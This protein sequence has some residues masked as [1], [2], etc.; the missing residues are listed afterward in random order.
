M[1]RRLWRAYRSD[2]S[3]TRR[4]QSPIAPTELP[5]KR[6]NGERLLE[7]IA[8]VKRRF[9]LEAFA[10]RHKL[11]EG[12]QWSTKGEEAGRQEFANGSCRFGARTHRTRGVEMSS[13]R[14]HSGS[15]DVIAARSAR[16]M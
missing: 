4:V 2:P 8:I 5:A 9:S 15:I 1:S 10:P 12:K 13:I 7:E 14:S 3:I 16:A 6:P 11:L